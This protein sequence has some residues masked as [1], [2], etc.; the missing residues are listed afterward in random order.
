ME[1]KKQ[2]PAA[3]AKPD[4]RIMQMANEA[5]AK[6]NRMTDDQRQAS[7]CHGMQLIYGGNAHGVPAKAGRP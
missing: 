6:A 2:L 7:L 3:A 4:E 1:P 5:R